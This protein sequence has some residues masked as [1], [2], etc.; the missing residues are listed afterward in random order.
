M[1][2][3]VT[4]I[5]ILIIFLGVLGCTKNNEEENVAPTFSEFHDS[6]V[7]LRI[8]KATFESLEKERVNQVSKGDF[9][10][11]N[12]A[13]RLGGLILI[14]VTYG[15]GCKDHEFEVIWD[16]IIYNDNPCQFNLLITHNGNNDGCKALITK[17][18]AINLKELLGEEAFNK[19][20]AINIFNTF[21][22]SAIPDV[23]LK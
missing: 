20:C 22:A 7:V 5:G 11:I 9:F 4:N 6:K 8:N 18:I 2:K 10:K 17:D 3:L 23:K 14:N 16:G 1:K 19:F 12:S 21:N 13:E 15:G